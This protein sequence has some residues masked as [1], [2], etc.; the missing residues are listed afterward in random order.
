VTIP[1]VSASVSVSAV[2]DRAWRTARQF[3]HRYRAVALKTVERLAHDGERLVTFY[4]F[5][6][7]HW[8]HLRTMNVESPFAAVRLRNTEG[9]R[10]KRVESATTLIW[11]VL[12]IAEPVFRRL[13]APNLLPSL[14]AGVAYV[15]GVQQRTIAQ[16]EIAA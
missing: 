12:Q 9:K 2:R 6:R 7:E 11:E 3:S 8:L 10:S 14:Y 16:K 5:P 15:E 13:I 1:S 4:Q